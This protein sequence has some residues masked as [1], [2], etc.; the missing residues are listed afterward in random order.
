MDCSPADF[1]RD[2]VEDFVSS[3][4]V[5]KEDLDDSFEGISPFDLDWGLELPKLRD[6][7]YDSDFDKKS[8]PKIDEE[9]YSEEEAEVFI[10]LKNHIKQACN[11]NTSW[12]KRK[13]ALDW[14]FALGEKTPEGLDFSTAC[15]A[16]GARPD[17]MRARIQH[18]LYVAGIPLREPLSF[19]SDP[20]PDQYESEAIMAAWEDGLKIT[21]ELWK[22]PGIPIDLLE[23][24][25]QSTNFFETLQKLEKVG[26]VAWR[27]GCV[28]LI[29]RS[30]DRVNARV[31]SWSRS[32]Y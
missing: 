29:G 8:S 16:L 11:V 9:D 24:K 23:E 20:I 3:S 7:E 30:P 19:W 26:L 5:P 28:F 13:K 21:T 10:I 15:M 18:Q 2:S 14:C 12:K 22:W 25:M 32:F 31:F 27:F 1:G 4:P 17:V 6:Q